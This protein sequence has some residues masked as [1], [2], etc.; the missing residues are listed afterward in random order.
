MGTYS[1]G[2]KQLWVSFWKNGGEISNTNSRIY[3]NY[4][5]SFGTGQHHGQNAGSAI[6]YLSVGEYVQ[7]RNEGASAVHGAYNRFQGFLLSA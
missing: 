2:L 4:D 1:S 6:I 5:A 7:M 3:N